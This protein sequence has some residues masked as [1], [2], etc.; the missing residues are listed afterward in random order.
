MVRRRRSWAWMSLLVALALVAAGCGDDDGDSAGGNGG[1]GG[2]SCEALLENTDTE[3]ADFDGLRVGMVFDI[4]G[5]GDGS[6][7]DSAAIGLDC[8]RD[9]FDIETRDLEPTAAGEGRQEN[10]ELLATEGFDLNFGVG[11]LFE[12]PI[13]NVAPAHPET[14]FAIID[15]PGPE[16]ENVVGIQFAANQGSFLVGAA[17][18]LKT[19][20]NRIGFV[21]GQPGQLIG[22]FEAGFVAGVAEANPDATVEVQYISDDPNIA[23]TDAARAKEIAASMIS[24]GADIVFHAA[25]TAGTGVFEAVKDA[26]D[27]GQQVWAI[28]VDSDQASDAIASVSAEVKPYI[29]TSMLKR[30]DVAVFDTIV[31]FAKGELE[32]GVVTYDLAREGVGYSTTGGH[33]DDIVDQLDE[34]KQ[35]IIDGDIVVPEQP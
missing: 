25:G 5:R 23:F 1:G 7:N 29:L 20:S 34:Y 18:G 14:M 19:Q 9:E 28:G 12:D 31:A 33:I 2:A 22:A 8:A 11:F 30:L 3:G 13:N 4:T 15:A 6:F 10:L 16:A 17:A 27:R 21:G 24:D 32:P 26:N 35:Q